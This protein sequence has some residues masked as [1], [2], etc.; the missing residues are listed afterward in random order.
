MGS[1]FRF[2]LKARR[3]SSLEEAADSNAQIL[4]NM[5]LEAESVDPR[6]SLAIKQLKDPNYTNVLNREHSSQSNPIVGSPSSPDTLHV[7]IVEDNL[8]NQKVSTVLKT[9]P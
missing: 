4:E 5:V 1:T 2:Y 7:L 8:I 3:A 9:S 6:A